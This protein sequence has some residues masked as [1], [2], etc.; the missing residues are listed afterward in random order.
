MSFSNFEFPNTNFYDSDLREFISMYKKLVKEY[1]GILEQ[2]NELKTNIGSIVDEY[3]DADLGAFKAELLTIINNEITELENEIREEQKKLEDDITKF[4]NDITS[5]VEQL[6]IDIDEFEVKVNNKVQTIANQIAQ[7]Y[8]DMSEYKHDMAELFELQ[9][10]E[11]ILYIQEHIAQITRLYVT[12]PFTGVYE[13]VQD[14]LNDIAKYVTQSYGLTAQEY[15]DL[16]LKASEYDAKRIT[17]QNY[18]SRG[19]LLFFKE[20]Y[21]KMRSPF[22]GFMD[23][24]DKIIYQLADLHRSAYTAEEYDKLLLT[25]DD[26][27]GLGITAFKYDWEIN[28]KDFL[29]KLQQLKD[30]LVNVVEVGNGGLTVTQL[31][32]LQ[33]LHQLA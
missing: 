11:L 30:E 17:A 18:S 29:A 12:N 16:Q 13:D 4:K 8:I 6:R 24:Y 10:N 7:V 20:L 1:D 28:P 14:V 9:R 25:A 32:N 22:T 27:D 3:L 5:T 33:L 23:Y 21:L 15:D 19:I 2:L 26:Y 31:D